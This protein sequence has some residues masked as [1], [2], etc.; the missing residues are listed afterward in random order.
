[1]PLR[2]NNGDQQS[3]K[4]ALLLLSRLQQGR[5]DKRTWKQREEHMCYNWLMDN[6]LSATLEPDDK[7]DIATEWLLQEQQ[8]QAAIIGEPIFVTIRLVYD[9]YIEVEVVT[10]TGRHGVGVGYSLATALSAAVETLLYLDGI[11]SLY[12]SPSRA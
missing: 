12:T 11:I 7:P 6:A 3:T 8:R 10:F 1:M 4:R 5:A 2:E 9:G